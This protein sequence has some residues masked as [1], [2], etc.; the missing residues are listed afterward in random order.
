VGEA[1]VSRS[2]AALKTVL[3]VAYY[4]PPSID[5]GAKRA[6]GF[7][8]YLPEHGYDPIVLTV[9]NGNYQT[10]GEVR[11]DG[12]GVVRVP[13]RKFLHRRGRNDAG[14]ATL[15]PL[16]R[17]LRRIFREVVYCP[18][19]YRGFHGPAIEAAVAL[20]ARQKIDVV[21]TTSSPFTLLRT[22]HALRRRGMGPWV[23]DLRD[24]WV[25]NHFG[26]PYSGVR[27]WLDS[28]LERRWLS[29]ASCI[30]TAT[31][32]LAQILRQ[33]GYGDRPI[34]C[35]YNGHFDPPAGAPAGGGPSPPSRLRICYTGTVYARGGDSFAPFFAALA[36]LRQVRPD[37]EVETVFYGTITADFLRTRDSF[38]LQQVVTYGG[39][40]SREDAARQQRAADVLLIV[41]PD[42]PQ[43]DVAVCSKTFDYMV[44]RRPVLAILPRSGENARVLTS[45]GSGRVFAPGDV[46]AMTAWLAELLDTKRSQGR[47]PDH[48]DPAKISTFHYRSLAGQMARVLDLAIEAA[49]RGAEG[50]SMP[51]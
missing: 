31:D 23:A 46:E 6:E 15:S 28:R 39:R 16:Q 43:Q 8:R 1:V 47:L 13:E 36:R 44:A 14:V 40:L 22:G 37:V 2:S 38:G 5:A 29:A 25:Q 21:L 24:L 51:R 11:D 45:V 35:I 42:S 19:A 26:Y 20:A 9:K 34:R 41:L 17:F 27:R 30:T 50:G 48:G 12:P 3:F 32:G 18:D 33:G 10:A 4:Y 49:A 7:A